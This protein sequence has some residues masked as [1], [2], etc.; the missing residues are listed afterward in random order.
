MLKIGILRNPTHEWG[1]RADEGIY[2]GKS[3]EWGNLGTMNGQVS[4]RMDW[5]VN[6]WLG[7]WANG[8]VSGRMDR[9]VDEWTG[10]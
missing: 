6:Q 2:E 5:S 3:H 9:S 8:Q 7:Q 1:I 10:Q 4:G